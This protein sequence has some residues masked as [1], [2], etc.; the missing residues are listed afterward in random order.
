MT[1]KG[2]GRVV[3]FS[4]AVAA[5]ALTL[6]ITPLTDIIANEGVVGG[7]ANIQTILSENST[8]VLAF[9]IS[10]FVIISLWHA[11]HRM[12]DDVKTIDSNIYRINS[13]WLFSIV[14]SHLPL[15]QFLVLP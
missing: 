3:F 13:F 11:H 10:F 2:F 4:D 6:L 14:V 1:E 9:I 15:K 5:F 7:V 12:F 8:A